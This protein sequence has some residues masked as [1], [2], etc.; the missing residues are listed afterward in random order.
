MLVV[1]K[2]SLFAHVMVLAFF[3]SVASTYSQNKKLKVGLALP[4][5]GSVQ[6]L[7]D[8]TFNGIK[9]YIEETPKLTDNFELI[10]EDVTANTG[11]GVSAVRKLV[12]VDKIDVLIIE[13]SPV[14]NAVAPLIDSKEIPTL[15]IVGDDC[16]TNR[17]FMV[18]LWMP[19]INE[20]RAVSDYLQ[21]TNRTKIALVTTEQDAMLKRREAL[22][23][24]LKP[25]TIVFDKTILGIEDL[26]ILT[27]QIIQQ[28]ADIL[29]MN[30]MPGQFGVLS[31]RLREQGFKGEFIGNIAMDQ[32]NEYKLSQGILEGSVF[33][34]MQISDKFIKN[35]KKRFGAFPGIGAANGYDAIKLIDKAYQSAGQVFD[36]KKMNSAIR[37]S[38]FDGAMGNYSF[39]PDEKNSYD[40]PSIVDRVS[41]KRYLRESAQNSN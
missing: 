9:L 31:R 36:R 4:L 29:V 32:E 23:S 11:Q 5:S 38:N 3:V 1:M 19:A 10:V 21:K 22:K 6:F 39:I 27:M 24:L 28:P 30:L 40:I 18:K 15:A 14:T 17:K 13:M 37:I 7:G 12:D 25:E 33:P 34:Y 35:Y 8:N 16:A 41:S 20:A 26:S 2:I